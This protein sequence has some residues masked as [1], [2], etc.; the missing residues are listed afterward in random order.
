MPRCR[1]EWQCARSI[2]VHG[3]ALGRPRRTVW[4]HPRVHVQHAGQVC[5]ARQARG[6]HVALHRPRMQPHM[7]IMMH[8]AVCSRSEARCYSPTSLLPRGPPTRPSSPCT[9]QGAGAGMGR[10]NPG[11]QQPLA[12]PPAHTHTTHTKS[13]SP[14]KA[15][16]TPLARDCSVYCHLP[17]RPSRPLLHGWRTG[18]QCA[19]QG[20]CVCRTWPAAA[21][22]TGKHSAAH[23]PLPACRIRAHPSPGVRT[24]HSSPLSKQ[25][26]H[27][28]H[29]I[30]TCIHIVIHR[31]L[32][33]PL[34]KASQPSSF[35]N[36]CPPPARTC[37][38]APTAAENGGGPFLALIRPPSLH[39]HGFSALKP[40]VDCPVRPLAAMRTAQHCSNWCPCPSRHPPLATSGATG[41]PLARPQPQPLARPPAPWRW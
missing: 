9:A 30:C 19:L 37:Q 3:F 1:W 31:R 21:G 12:P 22:R 11:W 6:R 20:P 35:H 17:S 29:I 27:Q 39:G 13:T 38:R 32:A 26:Q 23:L 40:A 24:I 2:T 41:S 15:S 4:A 14:C 16:D 34:N 33:G 25:C 36:S 8:K 10:S 7:M 28:S 18:Q 5:H